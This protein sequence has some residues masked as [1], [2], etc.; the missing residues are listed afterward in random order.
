MSKKLRES[1]RAGRA[2]A[3]QQ[4][5]VKRERTRRVLI[6]LAVVAVLAGIVLAGVLL[7]GGDSSDPEVKG[8]V[9]VRAEGQALVL[10]DDTQATRVVVYEDFLCPYCWEFEVASSELLRERASS[11][12][13]IV[14]YRPFKLL[15]D[16]YSERSLTAW[17]A[18]LQGGTPQQ[19]LKFHDLLFEN[20]PYEDA[21]DKPGSQ[22]LASLA[23]E[24]G[25]GDQKVLDAISE[26]NLAF[27]TA[28]TQTA[29]DS[30]CPGDADSVRGRQGGPVRVCAQD[31]EYA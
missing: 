31:A 25:V 28:S 22:E 2:A 24:A 18:V 4:A 20:Q 14:E 12:N 15:Q 8:K 1:N 10:G 5:H 7:S 19:A 23:E 11:G 26:P 13:A 6:T 27:V 21:G 16:P 3:I 30:G 17:A 9:P 29:R